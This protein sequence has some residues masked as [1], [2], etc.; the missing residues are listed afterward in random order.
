[1]EE[2]EEEKAAPGEKKQGYSGKN[3]ND[4]ME[5]MIYG[6]VRLR[7][8]GSEIRGGRLDV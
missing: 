5:E 6:D 1:M 4:I 7:W 3:D 2:Q 8:I